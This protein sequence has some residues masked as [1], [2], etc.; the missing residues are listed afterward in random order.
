MSS[1]FSA[2]ALFGHF[3]FHDRDGFL[4]EL[5]CVYLNDR[6][7]WDTHIEYLRDACCCRLHISKKLKHLISF[8]K[9]H[10]VYMTLILFRIDYVCPLFF[11]LNDKQNSILR[12]I[13]SLAHKLMKHSRTEQ[14]DQMCCCGRHNLKERRLKLTTCFII[15]S[16]TGLLAQIKSS[17]LLF[18][19]ISMERAFSPT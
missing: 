11:G 8:P 15:L 1:R 7:T 14:T 13:A 3:F 4:L 17:S 2:S 18:A 6:L 19:K 5:L 12:K 10:L 16:F 9:L